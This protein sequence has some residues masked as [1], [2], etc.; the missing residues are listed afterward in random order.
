MQPIKH[1]AAVVFLFAVAS[2]IGATSIEGQPAPVP[3]TVLSA[4]TV[5]I[6]NETGFA[7]LQY[8]AV[9]ELNKWGQ[10]QLADS[11]EKADLVLVLSSGTHVRAIPDGQYPRA[12]GLNAFTEETVPKGHTKLTL[13]DPKSGTFLWSD[14]HKTE[15]GKVKSGHLLDELRQAYE[16]AEKARSKR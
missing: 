13:Q 14:F 16:D 3:E 9:L 8:I 10:F 1:R 15:G 6:E 2:I 5:F 12:T 7:E 4:H 11:R